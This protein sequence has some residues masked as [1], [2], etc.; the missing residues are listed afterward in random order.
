MFESISY[1]NIIFDS[2]VYY[3]QTFEL[4]SI[5]SLYLN[6]YIINDNDSLEISSNNDTIN[7]NGNNYT[8]D[9]PEAR[10][11]ES[12]WENFPGFTLKLGANWNISEYSNVFFNSGILSKAP[13]FN[14]V[15]NET[16]A[17]HTI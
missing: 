2:T 14:N 9:S 6:S 16:L 3:L 17:L 8:I 5:Q 13:R 1:N 11:T 4:D 12:N 10:H 7:Y 15:F